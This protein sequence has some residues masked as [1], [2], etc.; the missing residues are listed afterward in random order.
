MKHK[1]HQH[2]RLETEKQATAAAVTTSCFVRLLY[3]EQFFNALAHADIHY[4]MLSLFFCFFLGSWFFHF[5]CCG[6]LVKMNEFVCLLFGYLRINRSSLL[7]VIY[8]KHTYI[9]YMH[10][11]LNIFKNQVC[12]FQLHTFF[13]SLNMQ[14]HSDSSTTTATNFISYYFETGMEIGE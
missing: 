14:H 4:W 8:I 1:R 2:P 7:F 12:D 11:C 3:D 5:Y 13:S 6:L 9:Q 10:V